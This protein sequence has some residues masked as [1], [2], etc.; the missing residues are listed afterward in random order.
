M[1]DFRSKDFEVASLPLHHRDP[2]ETPQ[3]R[4]GRAL[5]PGFCHG[6]V[7]K[8]HW[9]AGKVGVRA[10][11]ARKILDTTLL[12][13]TSSTKMRFPKCQNG[14]RC[15]L[16]AESPVKC[17]GPDVAHRLDVELLEYLY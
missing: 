13:V 15:M 17:T 1:K 3:R 2:F 7:C 12:N 10:H 6:V 4:L 16:S 5:P 8:S 14:T 11:G 9:T